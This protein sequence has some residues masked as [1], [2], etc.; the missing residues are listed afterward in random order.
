M[1]PGDIVG[2]IVHRRDPVL[3][4]S[5]ARRL[6]HEAEVHIVTKAVSALCEGLPRVAVAE[7][8]DPV[9]P[10]RPG[11]CSRKAPGMTPHLRGR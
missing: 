11:V 9:L 2:K 7:V 8:V 10:N 3:G 4:V 6:K 5:L 1:R